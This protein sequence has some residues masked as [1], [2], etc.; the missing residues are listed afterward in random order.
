MKYSLATIVLIS[1]LAISVFG[2]VGLSQLHNQMGSNCPGNVSGGVTCPVR[3]GVFA[4]ALSHLKTLQGLSQ[5]G[6]L[7]VSP[8]FLLSVLLLAF[9]LALIIPEISPEFLANQGYFRKNYEYKLSDA[10]PN[11][12]SWLSHLERSPS[13]VKGA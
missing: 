10:G 9:A 6:F 1:F 13:F 3:D 2:F 4:F 5:S 11:V 8:I 7:D 12:M